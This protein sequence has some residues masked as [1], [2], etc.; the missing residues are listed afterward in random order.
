MTEKSHDMVKA[1]SKIWQGYQFIITIL[2]KATYL[3]LNPL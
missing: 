1:Y 3:E 2:G